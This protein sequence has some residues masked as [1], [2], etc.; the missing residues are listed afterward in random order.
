MLISIVLPIYNEEESLD[1]LFD[2]IIH[3]MKQENFDYEIIAVNDGSRDE[4]LKKLRKKS[5]ENNLIKVID[6]SR[7]FGQTAALAA[8]FEVAKGEIIIPMD[9]DLQNDPKDIPI[10]IKKANEG[11]DVVSGWRKNRQDKLL[12]RKIPSWIANALISKITKVNLHDYGCT[13]KAYKTNII[14]DVK[15]YGEMHRFIPALAVWHGAKITEIVT[16]HRERKFG[17][18][19]YG[20]SRTIRVVLDLLT[21]KFLTKYSTRPMHFFGG[22][23]FISISLGVIA[24]FIA[25]YLKFYEATSLIQ[26][27]LPLIG[28]FF[29]IVGVQLILMGLLAEMIMRNYFELGDR[30]TYK[31]K[32]KINF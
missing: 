16:N 5:S 9:A 12:S 10:L 29:S 11:F 3:V 7:N 1:I 22:V 19:K 26:T 14:K 31:I 30:K 27:P 15:L 20:I 13:L 6:F 17:Q 28:V 18:T 4:S 8:G 2:E 21:V 25:L 23:G 32:E 24:F